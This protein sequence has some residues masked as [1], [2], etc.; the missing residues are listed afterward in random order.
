[1]ALNLVALIQQKEKELIDQPTVDRVNEIMDIYRQAAEKFEGA[2]DP[3]H[4]EVMAHM[5]RFLN[6]QFTT[7]I[8]DGTFTK[9]NDSSDKT[10]LSTPAPQGKILE[11]PCY[12]LNDD[13]DDNVVAK[14]EKTET[15][16]KEL[17][18]ETTDPT[19][20]NMEDILK[21]AV[22]DM[23]DLGIDAN[24]I[25]TKQSPKKPMGTETDDLAHHDDTY[26][27]LDAMLNDANEELNELLNS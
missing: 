18:D 7:S 4:S 8:L 10:T 16:T 14:K 13:K 26:A 3:R 9:S 6:Q 2:G 23:S 1:M 27:E 24:D 22:Q 17:S 25:L 5:K 19:L 12:P 20:Q 11:Q 15:L 21:E